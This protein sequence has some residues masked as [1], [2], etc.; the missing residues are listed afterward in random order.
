MQT[1]LLYNVMYSFQVT[2]PAGPGSW[3]SPASLQSCSWLCSWCWK[4]PDKNPPHPTPQVRGAREAWQSMKKIFVERISGKQVFLQSI[5]CICVVTVGKT[6]LVQRHFYRKKLG[7]DIFAGRGFFRSG[8]NF[9]KNIITKFLI[10]RKIPCCLKVKM[11]FH[12]STF[13]SFSW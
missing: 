4:A 1:T 11:Y 10:F 3:P 9:Q 13:M 8:V 5:I 12:T 6:F 7:K 2:P